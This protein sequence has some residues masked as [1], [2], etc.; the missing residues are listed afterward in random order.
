MKRRTLAL[1]LTVAMLIAAAGCGTAGRQTDGVAA[2]EDNAA[3]GTESN[4]GALR[5]ASQGMFSAGGTVTDP[6]PGAYNETLNWQDETR[7]GN[8]M[9]VDHANVF[10]QIPAN[11]NGN[12]IVF[13]TAQD[14]PVWVG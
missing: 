7:T 5:I 14:S 2:T 4:N 13:Y 9:H 10:Y 12:P 3:A 6:I 11:D 1:L 8:T